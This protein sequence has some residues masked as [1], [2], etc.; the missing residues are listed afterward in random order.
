MEYLLDY[1][2]A[3]WLIF[4]G[5]ILLGFLMG[6]MTGLFGAGGGF[7]L[8][9]VLNI[10]MGLPM[11]I[12]VGTSSCQVFGASTF[13]LYHHFDKRLLGIRVAAFMS[14]GIPAGSVLGVYAVR[15]L[16]RFPAMTILGRELKTVD[17]ILLAFFAVFLSLISLFLVLDNFYL[18]KNKADDDSSHKGLLADLQIFPLVKF[19]TIPAGKFSASLLVLIGF[20][21]GF[22]SGFLGIGGGVI[23]IPVLFYLVGQETKYAALTGTMLILVSCF[24]STIGHALNNNIDYMLVLILLTGAFFGTKLGADM[25]KKISGRSIR[26]YFAVIV[27]AAAMIVIGK[28]LKMLLF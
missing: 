15:L 12:A 6:F 11:N 23:I 20:I 14:L 24:F 28:L 26:R 10:F 22:I 17:F 7:I 3:H 13:S 8:T 4:A 2:S 1:F 16:T 5:G 9:P 18:N 27:M 25:Q 19:R 21:V